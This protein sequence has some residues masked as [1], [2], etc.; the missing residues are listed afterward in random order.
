MDRLPTRDLRLELKR[1]FLEKELPNH[2]TEREEA[3]S[4]TASFV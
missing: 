4:H 2:P 1:K 3:A